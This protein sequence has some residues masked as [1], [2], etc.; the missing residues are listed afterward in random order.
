MLGRRQVCQGSQ[1]H[2]CGDGGGGGSPPATIAALL[3]AGRFGSGA[4]ASAAL[5]PVAG[6]PTS[7]SSHLAFSVLQRAIH[8]FYTS[9]SKQ[10]AVGCRPAGH[11]VAVC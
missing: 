7:N 1:Q 4:G 3:P 5:P 11:A 6:A 8:R 2:S 9:F 10:K